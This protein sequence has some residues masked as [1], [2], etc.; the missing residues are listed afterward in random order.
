MIAME[1]RDE[2]GGSSRGA[3]SPAS[4]SDL[5]PRRVPQNIQIIFVTGRGAE[6]FI[7]M[8]PFHCLLS[9]AELPLGFLAVSAQ[10]AHAQDSTARPRFLIG[11]MGG[12]NQ[13][14]YRSNAFPI[15][16]S[17]PDDF[18]AQNG[19]G[20][21]Y[22]WGANYEDP[23]S[24]E[25]HHFFILEVGYASKPG[26]FTLHSSSPWPDTIGV[27]PLS[28]SQPHD[29]VVAITA[30]ALT[31]TLSYIYVNIGY[32]FNF[33]SDTLPN[34]FGVQLCFSVGIKAG[35]TFRKTITAAGF[36]S[37]TSAI[38]VTTAQALRLALRPEITYDLPLNES[39]ILTPFVGFDYPLTQVDQP[40]DWTVSSAYG[41]MALR[42]AFR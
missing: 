8:K 21:G 12:Y 26:T 4:G 31:A 20:H 17:V 2:K 34:G 19:S 18:L 1:A 24:Q 5:C 35:A 15:L 14:F 10:V 29:T 3:S 25:M 27:D 23:L 22:F 32:K 37:V 11:V 16:N 40:E 6:R 7:I 9:L 28:G 38:S 33:R 42:F 30:E 36:G 13:E 41:G 39:F